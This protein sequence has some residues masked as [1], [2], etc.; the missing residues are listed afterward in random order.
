MADIYISTWGYTG[1]LPYANDFSDTC[2]FSFV[3]DSTT[4][5]NSFRDSI[6]I[7]KTYGTYKVGY[8]TFSY[9]L[10][11]DLTVRIVNGNTTKTGHIGNGNTYTQWVNYNHNGD[12]DVDSDGVNIIY[13]DIPN[14]PA[15]G[16]QGTVTIKW[17]AVVRELS[18]G[19]N[20][21]INNPTY[22]GYSHYGLS[23]LSHCSAVQTAR[24]NAG[25]YQETIY[26]DNGSTPFVDCWYFIDSSNK[27]VAQKTINWTIN[28]ADQTWT[29][30]PSSITMVTSSTAQIAID[31]SWTGNISANIVDSTKASWSAN[32]STGIITITSNTSTGSTIISVSTPGNSNIQPRTQTATITI[33]TG[34]SYVRIYHNGAWGRYI[35]YIYTN[36]SWHKAVAYVYTNNQ[37]KEVD[38]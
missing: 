25:T 21:T 6:T 23:Q 7:G 28:K 34:D 13:I 15:P 14:S 5:G 18:E 8:L 19:T 37:W 22:D 2:S 26:A 17:N 31:G 12:P 3:I 30:D 38:S 35:P 20:Y 29:L 27:P 32:Q 36:G 10:S 1:T 9:D 4:K 16:G 11:F 24:T 33:G